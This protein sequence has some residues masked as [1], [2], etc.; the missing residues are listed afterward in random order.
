MTATSGA[1]HRMPAHCMST[2]CMSA[3]CMSAAA[4]M[5]TWMAGS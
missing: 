5:T 3:H 1:S 2:H 4:G